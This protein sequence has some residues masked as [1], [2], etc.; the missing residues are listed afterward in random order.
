MPAPAGQSHSKVLV[1]GRSVATIIGKLSAVEV[2]A[3]EAQSALFTVNDLSAEVGMP[4]VL[5]LP[6]T[7]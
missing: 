2:L 1:L 3:V 4:A 6:Q 7:A 5:I